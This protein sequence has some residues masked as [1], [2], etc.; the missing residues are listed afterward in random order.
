MLPADLAEPIAAGPVGRD[1][2]PEVTDP[3]VRGPGVQED[4]PE[5]AVLDP[6]ARDEPRHRQPQAV[7]EDARRVAGLAAGHAP[8][9]VGVVGRIG[10]EADQLAA[11]KDGRNDGDVVQV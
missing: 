11:G 4:R 2:R 5:E 1:L 6:P 10:D 3:L 7:L 8:A 9:D